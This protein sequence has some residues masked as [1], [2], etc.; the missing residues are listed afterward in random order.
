MLYY[1]NHLMV[2]CHQHCHCT[3]N[4]HI[5]RH[6]PLKYY[7][8]DSLYETVSHLI[9]SNMHVKFTQHISRLSE[10]SLLGILNGSSLITLDRNQ[11]ILDNNFIVSRC[12]QK[13]H[14]TH[15]SD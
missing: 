15:C 7:L 14:C 13:L 11:N 5:N 2:L 10:E 8:F 1:H 3:N 12:K 4:F 9:Q 6:F